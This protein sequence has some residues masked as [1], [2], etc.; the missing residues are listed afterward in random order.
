MLQA[1]ILLSIAHLI[2]ILF[3]IYFYQT[4]EKKDKKRAKVVASLMLSH[5]QLV[6]N[7]FGSHI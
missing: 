6:G 1:E 3:T 7:C 5:D 2:K 4:I